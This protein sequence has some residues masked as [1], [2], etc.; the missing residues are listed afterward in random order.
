MN[1]DPNE[2]E[3]ILPS[4]ENCL[5]KLKE[6]N[7]FEPKLDLLCTAAKHC[8]NEMCKVLIEKFNFGNLFKNSITF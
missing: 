4:D 1:D 3:S 5:K 6:V 8:K 7:T 2:F